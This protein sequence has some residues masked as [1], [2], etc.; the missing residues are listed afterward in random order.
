MTTPNT[1]KT[2]DEWFNEPEGYAHRSERFYAE[3]ETM[4]TTRIV[5]WLQTAW[6]LGAESK[7]ND[8][9][10]AKFDSECG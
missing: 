10:R 7:S 1:Y 5:E 3:L 4:P 9:L 8:S 2:F 6:E